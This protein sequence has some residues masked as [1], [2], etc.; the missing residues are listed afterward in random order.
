LWNVESGQP[1]AHL[2]EYL[3]RMPV[4][5][6]DYS[7]MHPLSLTT[8]SHHPGPTQ[9]SKVTRNLG[10]VGFQDCHQEAHADLAIPDQTE[11]PQTCSIRKRSQEGFD[12]SVF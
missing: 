11:Q 7:V 6:L 2:A 9:I 4:A 1:G 12:F 3:R 8:G 10:L 5:W